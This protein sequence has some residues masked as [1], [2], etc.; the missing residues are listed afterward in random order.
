MRLGFSGPWR[1]DAFHLDLAGPPVAGKHG[2]A[3]LLPSLAGNGPVFAGQVKEDRRLGQVFGVVFGF[4]G[5]DRVDDIRVLLSTGISNPG[6]SSSYS[7]AI[8]S[9]VSTQSSVVMS[10]WAL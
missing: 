2:Q 7:S 6:Q 1:I 9:Q 10:I 8:H 4:P 3:G 5:V